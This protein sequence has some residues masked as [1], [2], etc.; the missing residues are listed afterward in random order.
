MLAPANRCQALGSGSMPTGNGST[1][2]AQRLHGAGGVDMPAFSPDL[3]YWQGVVR[4]WHRLPITSLNS[5][6]TIQFSSK[7]RWC[8]SVTC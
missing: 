8:S 5:N 7:F 6:M 2:D 4:I 1:S 3:S